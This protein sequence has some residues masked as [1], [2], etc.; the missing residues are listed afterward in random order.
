MRLTAERASIERVPFVEVAAGGEGTLLAARGDFRVSSIWTLTGGGW[1]LLAEDAS[2]PAATER[3]VAFVR[4]EGGGSAIWIKR[5]GE[6]R[7]TDGGARDGSPAGRLGSPVIAFSSDRDGGSDIYVLTPGEEPQRLTESLGRCITP[8]WSP[9]GE[10]IA[11]ASD[12]D[13]LYQLFT[14]AADGSDVRKVAEAYGHSPA[15]SPGGDT[16]AYAGSTVVQS[17]RSPLPTSICTVSAEGGEPGMVAEA[18]MGSSP[19]WAGADELYFVRNG[20]LMRLHVPSGEVTQMRADGSV[21][22]P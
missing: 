2:S 5:E 14:M 15:W 21:S 10:R 22:P 12:R 3:G 9:G 20:W 17:A 1:E 4:A 18:S 6:E 16:I 7:V 8:A 11:F 13:G 19:C